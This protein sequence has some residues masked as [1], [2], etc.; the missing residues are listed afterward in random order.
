MCHYNPGD[1]HDIH[2]SGDCALFN[3]RYGT[4]PC[5]LIRACKKALLVHQALN[6]S[7]LALS[8]STVSQLLVGAII[9]SSYH[10]P[11]SDKVRMHNS[12]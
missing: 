8:T 5:A 10:S 12:Q 3:S 2:S 4:P 7:L 1:P 9:Y 11:R 6:S